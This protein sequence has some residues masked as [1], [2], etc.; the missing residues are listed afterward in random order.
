MA[1]GAAWVLREILPALLKRSSHAE[2]SG[3]KDPAYWREAF[4]KEV[5]D[6]TAPSLKE[7]KELLIKVL[8]RLDRIAVQ[9]KIAKESDE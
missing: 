3:S 9:L 5:M 1:L 2:D 7:N 4:R 6:V 8:G